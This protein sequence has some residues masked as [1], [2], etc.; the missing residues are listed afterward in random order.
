LIKPLTYFYEHEGY[1][2]SEIKEIVIGEKY[3]GIMLRNGNIGVCA[4]LGTV[5][6]EEDSRFNSP[7]LSNPAHRI[8]YNAYLNAKLNYLQ[9]FSDEKDIFDHIDFSEKQRIVMIGYF[10][11]LVNKFIQKEIELKIFDRAQHDDILLNYELMEDYLSKKASVILTSTTI[12]NGTFHSI[13]QNVHED[14]EVFM[15]GPSS[16]LHSHMLSYGKIKMIYG[17][18]FKKEDTKILDLIREGHGTRYFLPFGRKV[19]LGKY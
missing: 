11:P 9:S 16:I 19:Y 12:S 1:E 5:I 7:D 13:I 2:P 8:I 15:L 17:A 4:R 6:S 18:V 10:K 14:S 3:A